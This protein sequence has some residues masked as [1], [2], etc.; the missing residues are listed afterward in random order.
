MLL[1][2][3]RSGLQCFDSETM[4]DKINRNREYW[5]YVGGIAARQCYCRGFNWVAIIKNYLL[6]V[7]NKQ[8]CVEMVFQMGYTFLFVYEVKWVNCLYPSKPLTARKNIP[9]TIFFYI[10]IPINVMNKLHLICLNIK[11]IRI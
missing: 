5:I 9:C 1:I 4:T 11:I 6:C 2:V 8:Y 3:G 10:L 7:Y